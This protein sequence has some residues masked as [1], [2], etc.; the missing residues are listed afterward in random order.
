LL[1]QFSITENAAEPFAQWFSLIEGEGQMESSKYKYNPEDFL[2]MMS[3]PEDLTAYYEACEAYKS[4]I[5]KVITEKERFR[6][7][8]NFE[9]SLRELF[10]SI[11]HRAVEGLLSPTFVSELENYSLDLFDETIGKRRLYD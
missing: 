4:E 8:F 11:K 6:V 2:G 5:D 3:L 1:L 9:K 7:D 10:L